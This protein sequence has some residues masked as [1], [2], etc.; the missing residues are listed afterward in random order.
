MMCWPNGEC[1][2]KTMKIEDIKIG[3]TL[4]IMGRTNIVIQEIDH[5]T[6]QLYTSIGPV[7]FENV[8]M[9]KPKT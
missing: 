8:W 6:K 4:S 7:P 5:D 2:D 1:E 9:L 3:D